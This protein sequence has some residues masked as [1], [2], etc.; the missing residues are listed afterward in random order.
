MRH[1]PP[2]DALVIAACAQV[3]EDVGGLD[4]VSLVYVARFHPAGE[5]AAE[6]FPR[7]G[8]LSLIFSSRT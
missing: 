4:R 7:D 3:E 2:D 1:A 8:S 5:V 6:K